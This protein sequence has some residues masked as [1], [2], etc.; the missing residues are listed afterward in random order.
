MTPSLSRPRHAARRA[1]S[2]ACLPLALCALCLPL[3]CAPHAASR[4]PDVTR[5]S[6]PGNAARDRLADL[7]AAFDAR[8]DRAAAAD[9]IP[10]SLAPS[11]WARP[12]ADAEQARRR[13]LSLRDACAEILA[14]A[15]AA[16]PPPPEVL[17]QGR[18]RALHL[19]ASARAKLLSGR[20]QDAAADLEAAT[21]F[22][23]ASPHLWRSLAEARLALGSGP[24]A[25][26]AFERAVDL[27]LDDPRAL[28][29]AG[30]VAIDHGDA[31]RA[32][33]ALALA[34]EHQ[35]AAADPLLPCVIHVSL[36]RALAELGYVAGA[37]E[38]LT[39][40]LEFPDPVPSATQYRDE[41][42][43]IARQRADLWRAAGDAA[44]ALARPA[45]AI[46]CYTR[47]ASAPGG[48]APGLL[49]RLVAAHLQAGN[50]PRAALA[51]LESIQR[52]PGPPGDETIAMA[53]HVARHAPTGAALAAAIDELAD[54][55]GAAPSPSARRGLV[56]AAAAALPPPRAAERLRRHL[57]HDPT[58]ALAADACIA[59]LADP[60]AAARVAARLTATHP[61]HADR[62]AAAI[63]RAAEFDPAFA[64]AAASPSR[65]PA[66]TLL[67]AC[68]LLASSR[69]D[70]AAR[71]LADAPPA[72]PDPAHALA[73]VRAHAGRG[74]WEP[75]RAALAALPPPTDPAARLALARAHR[76][77]QHPADALAAMAPLADDPSP[78][79]VLRVPLLLEAADLAAEARR[80]DLAESWLHAAR[81]L[82]PFDERVYRALLSLHAPEGARPDPPALAAAA[83]ALREHAPASRAA[84]FLRVQ[85][86][87]ARGLLPDAQEQ[88]LASWPRWGVD[89]ESLELLLRIW[90]RAAGAARAGNPGAADML[91]RADAW[92]QERLAA[93]PRSPALIAARAR[94]QV[95]RARAADAESLLRAALAE[96][97]D[98]SLSRALEWVLRQHLG[99][100]DDADALA[101]ERLAL[102]PRTISRVIEHAGILARRGRPA[103][104]AAL[105]RDAVP[106]D[107]SLTDE[108]GRALAAVLAPA[109][110]QA[111]DP[112]ARADALELIDV[113]AARGVPLPA[114]LHEERLRLL[115]DAPALDP[116]AAAA[117][118]DRVFADVPDQ[119]VGV[120][121]R[122]AES[123]V[124]RPERA[125]LLAELAAVKSPEPSMDAFWA[126]FQ[127]LAAAGD[128]DG[129]RRLIAAADARGRVQELLQR[130]V[131]PEGLARASSAVPAAEVV[132]RLADFTAFAGR[133][134][135]AIPFYR[136]ALEFDPSHPWA[137]NNL[138][139]TL[140]ERGESL[141]EAERLLET[142]YAQLPTDGS[143]LDS[144]AW[145]RYRRGVIAD[146]TD[147]AS[148]A[149]TRRGAL[150][151]LRDAV[152]TPKGRA[153]PTILD[154]FGDAL[155]AAGE[156]DQ[157][158]A[159]WARALVAAT[160]EL[161]GARAASLS[162]AELARVRDLAASLE[163]KAQA[164]RENRDPPIA[165]RPGQAT[166]RP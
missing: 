55:P 40:G 158:V 128:A 69:P 5:P 34:L 95:A 9:P 10:P 100:P 99:R 71:R 90:E 121:L 153:N 144:L 82:D 52:R 105:L 124:R 122:A 126:W 154:H 163:A 96:R 165:D 140:A 160:A 2:S 7:A 47:S 103:D 68:V 67:A 159:A 123:V 49:P 109:A 79:P 59:A 81:D 23:P 136:L 45:A 1:R 76:A 148:G 4:D 22:D 104:A 134:D 26:R 51:V 25:D 142:A 14:A 127:L 15:S 133:T 8:P 156:K 162:P 94:V 141:D 135:A 88:V 35:P 19:Y 74:A 84:R 24:G 107:A 3:A 44:L 114:S 157:A 42:V 60:D 16:A 18:L 112:R 110:G 64:D 66:R 87:V 50:P 33:R 58:D 38:S 166:P 143:I 12:P 118:V 150:S 57:E 39:R 92:L 129:A 63:L 97:H 61:I 48:D 98:E 31:A 70:D 146:E 86:L 139:Y 80:A 11:L 85:E 29:L 161:R 116:A 125:L 130:A 93:A 152:Q 108:Q 115:A 75:A 113:I 28:E 137:C 54:S 111:A 65:E 6:A 83:R 43:E 37:L 41:L 119:G 73:L 62:F 149:V 151:L 89:A 20:A 155:W 78:L 145:V 21:R 17:P 131:G 56:L 132:Y 164:V 30:R 13:E 106:L 36:G 101:L 91:E 120:V 77:L 53:R 147:P 27:G 72:R 102:A 117:A 138:G 46:D 32:A